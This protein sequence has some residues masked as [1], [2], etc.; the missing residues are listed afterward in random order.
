MVK[1]ELAEIL[2]NPDEIIERGDCPKSD[3]T[4]SVIGKSVLLSVYAYYPTPKG[5]VRELKDMI[6]EGPLSIMS[7][8]DI[9]DWGYQAAVQC[10]VGEGR[11]VSLQVEKF[12]S[13]KPRIELVVYECEGLEH[14]EG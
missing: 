7:V 11:I 5:T 9:A 1:H 4:C 13:I 12:Y 3:D 2:G 8:V 6:Y 10:G 14:S